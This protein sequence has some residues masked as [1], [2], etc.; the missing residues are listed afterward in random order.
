MR[1]VRALCESRLRVVITA[2]PRLDKTTP[3]YSNAYDAIEDALARLRGVMRQG[4]IAEKK[5][6]IAYRA[7]G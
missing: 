1:K 4:M 5:T 2:M 3:A 7:A 6:G